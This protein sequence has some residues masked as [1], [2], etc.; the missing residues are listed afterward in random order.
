MYTWKDEPETEVEQKVQTYSAAYIIDK[1]PADDAIRLRDE[2]RAYLDS[3]YAKGNSVI[4][5]YVW[6]LN[7]IEFTLK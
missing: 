3:E 7:K 6:F 1:I 5:W 2:Y 4:P